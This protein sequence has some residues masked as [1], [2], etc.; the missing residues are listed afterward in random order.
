MWYDMVSYADWLNLSHVD[1]YRK[2]SLNLFSLTTFCWE[3]KINWCGGRDYKS[4]PFPTTMC[5]MNEYI[6]WESAHH[7]TLAQSVKVNLICLKN[8][9]INLF[10]M[11]WSYL[12]V[13][14]GALFMSNGANSWLDLSLEHKP[15]VL[16]E[17][18]ISSMK[19][20]IEKTQYKY[21][22]NEWYSFEILNKAWKH[23][24]IFS[25][26]LYIIEQKTFHLHFQLWTEFF[27]SSS[28]AIDIQNLKLSPFVFPN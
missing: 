28:S 3:P 12:V 13:C 26:K 1:D 25:F 10:S 16:T 6:S 20:K 23:S 27:R 7:T 9:S 17:F 21:F 14:L 4:C 15:Y 2:S 18:F 22:F 24:E 19:S 8:K 5:V 11:S